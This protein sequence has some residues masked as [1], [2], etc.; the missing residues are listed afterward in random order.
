MNTAPPL[1]WFRRARRA[2]DGLVGATLGGAV[3]GGWTTA[4]NWSANPELALRAGAAHFALSFGLTLCGTA[5]MRNVFLRAAGLA[6]GARAALACSAGL[7][8]TYALLLSVHTAI[9]TPHILLSLAPGLVPNVA[10]CLTYAL[11]LRKAPP[12]AAVHA[13]APAATLLTR[14]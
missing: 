13:A 9:G 1:R 5:W 10:F 8:L 7:A 11:L 12:A 6:A 2:M 14:S 3:Y 4:V